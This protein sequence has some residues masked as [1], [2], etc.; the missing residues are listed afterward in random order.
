MRVEGVRLPA[1]SHLFSDE[2]AKGPCADVCGY[3]RIKRKVAA[4]SLKGT[5]AHW[6]TMWCKVK[7]K[8]MFY[9][10]RTKDSAP[11]E[12]LAL[13]GWRVSLVDVALEKQANQA[14]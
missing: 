14:L 10:G 7:R 11:M 6:H 8:A 13:I 12:T 2:P 4:S 5:A 1:R 9:F 3:L